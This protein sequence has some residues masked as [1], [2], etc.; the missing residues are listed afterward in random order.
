MGS[1][2]HPSDKRKQ[3]FCNKTYFWTSGKKG[4]DMNQAML[5]GV[6][7][8]K[9]ALQNEKLPKDVKSMITFL[10]YGLPSN[11]ETNGEAIKNNITNLNAELSTPIFST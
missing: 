4:A 8:V 9:F 1:E 7:L 11:A 10:T 5:E 3:N 6:K 2:S